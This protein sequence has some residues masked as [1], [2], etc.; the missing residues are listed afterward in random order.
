MIV[1]T[2]ISI[3]LHETSVGHQDCSHHICCKQCWSLVIFGA[4]EKQCIVGDGY[5]FEINNKTKINEKYELLANEKK[6][7]HLY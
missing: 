6:R 1:L 3:D 2:S 4:L 5:K 7:K